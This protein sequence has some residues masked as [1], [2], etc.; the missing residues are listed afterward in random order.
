LTWGERKNR[1]NR[2]PLNRSNMYI[3]AMSRKKKNKNPRRRKEKQ[4]LV[5]RKKF[6]ILNAM[7]YLKDYFM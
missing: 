3:P 4:P 6:L 1:S 7:V 2:I 5:N